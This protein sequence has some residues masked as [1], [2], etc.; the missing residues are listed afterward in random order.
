MHYFEIK[1]S[2]L[3]QCSTSLVHYHD[4]EYLL[5][6]AMLFFVVTFLINTRISNDIT[7]YNVYV[8]MYIY[9]YIYIYKYVQ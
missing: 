6:F 9:I 2:V 4:S 3:R 5:D 8:Y 1:C 7:T